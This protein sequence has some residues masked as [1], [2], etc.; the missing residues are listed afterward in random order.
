MLSWVKTYET[1]KM[2][3]DKYYNDH[4]L[5]K[6]DA[7]TPAGTVYERNDRLQ[8]AAPGAP[9]Y[10][11]NEAFIHNTLVG[12]DDFT[13]TNGATT[14]NAITNALT[15]A[16]DIFDIQDPNHIFNQQYLS[17]TIR[18]QISKIDKEGGVLLYR[19][20]Q[21]TSALSQF[22]QQQHYDELCQFSI[23]PYT[24]ID[25]YIDMPDV[26][27]KKPSTWQLLTEQMQSER[28]QYMHTQK[29]IGNQ[30]KPQPLP[31]IE[32]P[33]YDTM[34]T[35]ATQY[36]I[37]LII[38][39]PLTPLLD[40]YLSLK[41]HS[42]DH[43]LHQICLY[44]TT[45]K[46]KQSDYNIPIH[47][48]SPD[49]WTTAIS[50]MKQIT[51]VYTAVE[52]LQCLLTCCKYIYHTYKLL[53]Y[54]RQLAY[55]LTK[56][57]AT[58]NFLHPADCDGFHLPG[59]DGCDVAAITTAAKYAVCEGFATTVTK[60]STPSTTL[61]QRIIDQPRKEY[62]SLRKNKPVVETDIDYGRYIVTNRIPTW[63]EISKA[64]HG[65]LVRLVDTPAPTP[66]PCDGLELATH[67]TDS[68]LHS[69]QAHY[70]YT[71]SIRTA[72]Q[73][74]VARTQF[75][76]HKDDIGPNSS[77]CADD[78]FPIFVYVVMNAKISKL[79]TIKQYIGSMAP[80][81]SLTGEVGYYFTV[82]EAVIEYIDT[83]GSQQ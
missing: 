18:E 22:V 10:H 74:P 1:Y 41:C 5:A 2:A 30:D 73:L 47:L 49:K 57:H 12:D 11:K 42:K 34:V 31:R 53:L 80:R 35:H 79:E 68:N 33:D 46:R 28:E 78:F 3:Y 21:L 69:P 44:Y 56:Q 32:E 20:K 24:T 52:R 29:A 7:R 58:M 38:A 45:H 14:N 4:V 8:Q 62:L 27:I 65:I 48:Q 71:T 54:T 75:I 26:F 67:P 13:A 40:V 60:I 39:P 66:L 19:T 36:A 70:T 55:N 72:D 63:E 6:K 81:V 50:T 37:E 64:R 17:K 82:F 43:K 51:T 15:V 77:L 61:I 23:A 76:L 25:S 16:E 83:L 59:H 9:S